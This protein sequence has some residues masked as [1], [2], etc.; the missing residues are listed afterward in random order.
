MILGTDASGV[1]DD[2]REVIVH[3][4]VGDTEAGD[5]DETLD[6]R[7]SLLSE[8]YPG[9][10]G[11]FVRVPSHNLVDKPAVLTFEEAACLPTAY[12]TAYRMIQEKSGTAPGD[13]VLVQGAGGG[14]S[15]ALIVLGTALGRRVWVTSRD[16]AKLEW[17]MS[18][19]AEAAFPSGDSTG[20]SSS[21]SAS[22]GRRWEP[23][24]SCGSSSTCSSVP[25]CGPSSIGCCR[26]S[27]RPRPSP[28]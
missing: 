26:W 21:S 16:E 17:A 10:F 20:C 12:L 25:G 15:T 14:V 9:A 2:G 3:A 18:L 22:S 24:P 5:G 13:L 19:G 7:R 11:E 1:T 8:R 27:A 6:P 23:S 28:P 4:V